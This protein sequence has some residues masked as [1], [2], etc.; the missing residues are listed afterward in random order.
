MPS[1][2]ITSGQTVLFDNSI[3]HRQIIYPR[4]STMNS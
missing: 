4:S 1:A 3:K 2:K